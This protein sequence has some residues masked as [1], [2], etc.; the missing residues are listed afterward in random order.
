MGLPVF[1]LHRLQMYADF[2]ESLKAGP[3][4]APGCEA[5]ATNRAMLERSWQTV[6]GHAPRTPP[7]ARRA[8][9]LSALLYVSA[10]PCCT[11][12]SSA[13]T[14]AIIRRPH[15]EGCAT[16]TA[17]DCPLPLPQGSPPSPHLSSQVANEYYDPKGRFTQAEWA[18]QLLRTLQARGGV[19]RSQTDTYAALS[20]LLASLG[21][22]YSTFLPPPAF[23]RALRR[24][25]P[26][27]RSYLEAQYVGACVPT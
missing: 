26:A 10:T 16:I 11:T 8:Q 7:R 12:P 1:E 2:V 5:C 6:R 20:E 13:A 25:L 14:S 3:E 21:D 27:E 23:R 17:A 4:R 19:L 15:A 22:R 24:P 9:P 18:D